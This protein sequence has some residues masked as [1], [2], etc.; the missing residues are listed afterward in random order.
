M[1]SIEDQKLKLSSILFL[2]KVSI[3]SLN[4]KFCFINL[5]EEFFISLSI[6]HL[7]LDNTSEKFIFEGDVIFEKREATQRNNRGKGQK[8]GKNKRNQEIFE[9]KVPGQGRIRQSLQ[10]C[11]S[12]NPNAICSQN[13]FKK[14]N[15]QKTTHE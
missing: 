8:A 11:G 5:F 7:L 6:E 2:L 10:I 13:N 3:C 4:F 1:E 12:P 15:H 14:E 9:R